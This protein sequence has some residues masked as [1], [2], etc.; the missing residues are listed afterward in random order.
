M[1]IL[2]VLGGLRVG[3]YEILSVQIA[4]ALAARGNTVAVLS[5]SAD[6]RI[7]ERI[8]SSVETR[9]IRRYLKYDVSFLFRI[10][11]TVCD[12]E[13]DIVLC[14]AFYPYF[15]TRLASLLC[16]KKV[17]F[18]LAFHVTEPFDRREDRW[19]HVYTKFARLLKD[20][21]IAIHNSQVDFFNV[22][23]GLPRNRFT[24]IHNG[25]DT[26]HFSHQD[27]DKRNSVFRIAHVATL[28]PLKDQWSL[29]KSVVELGKHHKNWELLIAG[30]NQAGILSEYEDFVTKHGLSEKV[31]FLGPVPDTRDVL[32]LSDVF[33]L[34]SL[35]EALPISVI[36][37]IS[38]GLPCIVTDVG[39]NSDIIEHGREGFLVRP[40]DYKEIAKYL[41]FLADDISKRKEMGAAAR[42]KAIREF[43][44][45][46]MMKRYIELF[47]HMLS[48]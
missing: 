18:I 19:N 31:K 15:V 36:E 41:K 46:N 21:Y 5:L 6:S 12:L 27:V 20:N 44:F 3:G 38:M 11:R 33:V 13:P 42:E 23:Y 10:S 28:K 8:H 35:T 9:F 40:G 17:R 25:V 32:S 34:T 1:R 7:I 39:G 26:Q 14:C 47:N 22:R 30:A 16:R 4:N 29:L 45:N 24:V 43:D 2:F 37:A 48:N